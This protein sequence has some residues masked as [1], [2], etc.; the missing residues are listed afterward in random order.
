MHFRSTSQASPEHWSKDYVEHLR[1]VHFTLITI[2]AGA[3][4]II[5]SSKSYD[6]AIAASQMSEVVSTVNKLSSNQLASGKEVIVDYWHGSKSG[7]FFDIAT[8]TPWFVAQSRGANP[9]PGGPVFAFHLVEP[10]RFLCDVDNADINAMYRHVDSSLVPTNIRDFASFWDKMSGKTIFIDSV[11]KVYADGQAVLQNSLSDMAIQGPSTNL[12]NVVQLNI[13]AECD[14]DSIHTNRGLFLSGT[15]GQIAINFPVM[16]MRRTKIS[17][18]TIH[19]ECPS[20]KPGLFNMSFADLTEA[21]KGHEGE[22]LKSLADRISAQAAKGDEE[23]EA[24]G[25]RFPREQISRWG[26]LFIISIQL[27]LL[28]YIRRLSNTLKRDDPGWDVPWM[29]MDDSPLARVM[30]FVSMT[31]LPAGAALAIAVRGV[32]EVRKLWPPFVTMRPETSLLQVIVLACGFSLS[33]Y[34][35]ILSWKY[36]PKLSEPSAPAQLFE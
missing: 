13:A 8:L 14:T 2:S 16:S 24:F 30:L 25:L 27:Y 33:L 6:L 18:L 22:D 4:L 23:F 9:L 26:L 10:N 19:E 15:T 34:L 17:Q 32:C 3:L 12:N 21:I 29:A 5:L 20:V 28:I 35:S 36:R 11:D 1:A 7:S 31:V